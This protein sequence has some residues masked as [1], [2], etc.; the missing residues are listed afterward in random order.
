VTLGSLILAGVCSVVVSAYQQPPPGAGRG[1]QGPPVVDVEKLKDNL[2]VLKGGGG[3]TAVFVMAAGVTVVDAKNPGWGAPILAKIKELTP[4]PVT[5]LINTHTHGD[6]VS[7]NVEFPATVDVVVQE[8]TKTN[9]EKMAIFKE[10]AN[11]GMARRTFKDRMIIGSGA[12][13]IEVHYFGR[14]HTNGDAWVVFPSLR[15]VHAGDAFS[16]K[17]IPIIDAGNGGSGVEYPETLMKAHAGIRNVDTI[18][19]GH[20]TQM[21]MD[22]LRT[23]A[24][25]NRDFLNA[26]REAK[27]AGRSVDEVAGSWKI[28]AKYNGYAEPQAMR[29]RT[30][31][32]NV[33]NEIP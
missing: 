23:Y 14:A 22:D 24:D 30:N 19:T 32:Q 17:S 6:H 26:V 27:K 20:S 13:Q 29:L 9:M 3:N 28:P 21:T 10:N 1:Q 11:R 25:F 18:I 31:V 8:N 5:M 4:K 33:Y 15:V 16:G 12:D 2:F 7:G